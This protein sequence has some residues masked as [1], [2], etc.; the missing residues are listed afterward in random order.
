[1]RRGRPNVRNKIQNLILEN[2]GNFEVPLSINSLCK[3]ISKQ[4]GKSIS[5]NTVQKY[6]QELV[7]IGRVEAIQTMHSKIEG[8]QG[9]TVYS[10]KR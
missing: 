8:K 4:I 5:W 3:M 7:E 9:L 2:L 10:L 1:M 6:L